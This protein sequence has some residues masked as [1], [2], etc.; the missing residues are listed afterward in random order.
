MHCCRHV[1]V[2]DKI[3]QLLIVHIAECS[4]QI[5]HE[6]YCS[7]SRLFSWEPIVMSAV[8]VNSVVHVECFYRNVCWAG[9]KVMGV[10]ILDSSK[11]SSVMSAGHSRLIGRQF[12]PMLPSLPGIMIGIIIALCHNTGICLV[13]IGDVSEIVDGSMSELFEVEGAHPAGFDGC[14]RFGQSDR[15]V[16]D[17]R[18]KRR[19]SC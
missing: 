12:L 18:R 8:I 3:E 14:G 6:K 2:V 17:G 1:G 15:F 5:E 16:C 7:V 4:S 19:R 9:R 10:S 13:E 11:F